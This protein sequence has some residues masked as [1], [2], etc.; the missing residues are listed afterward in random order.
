LLNGAPRESRNLT[1]V[2]H[3]NSNARQVDRPIH[4]R[5]IYTTAHPRRAWPR[6]VLRWLFSGLDLTNAAR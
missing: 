1:A 6:R 2:E 3:V 5:V 4:A